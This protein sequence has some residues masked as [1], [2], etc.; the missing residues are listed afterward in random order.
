MLKHAGPLRGYPEER[1]AGPSLEGTYFHLDNEI[2][3]FFGHALT[4]QVSRLWA[5]DQAIGCIPASRSCSRSTA[6]ARSP[7][8]S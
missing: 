7:S 3:G 1:A 2:R 4:E 8:G 6:D 5:W